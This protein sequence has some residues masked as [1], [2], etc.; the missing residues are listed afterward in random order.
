MNDS[1]GKEI[2][3]GAFVF[4]DRDSESRR[5]ID[6]KPFKSGKGG[7]VVY[8]VTNGSAAT[9]WCLN[10]GAVVDEK[11]G[12]GATYP[13][14]L[15]QERSVSNAEIRTCLAC[16]HKVE[17]AGFRRW[18][19]HSCPHGNRCAVVGYRANPGTIREYVECPDC[20]K[21]PRFEVDDLQPWEEHSAHRNLS[22]AI[23]DSRVIDSLI[24]AQRESNWRFVDDLEKL[25]PIY[26]CTFCG[27]KSGKAEPYGCPGDCEFDEIK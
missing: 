2:S 9:D 18:V 10:T 17:S 7:V 16:G 22:T 15:E 11:H 14:R 26:K 27:R 19:P 5:V 25:G 6:L 1:K 23:V 12:D 8:K 24:G 3:I 4:V 13:V 21:A 20:A